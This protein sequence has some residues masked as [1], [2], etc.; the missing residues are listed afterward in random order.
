MPKEHTKEEFW[1]LYEKLPEDLKEMIF[2]EGTAD[3]IFNSCVRNGVDDE[4]ISEIAR[5]AGRVLLGILP[6]TEF[7]ETLERELKLEPE[8]AKRISRDIFRFVF[9]PV[10]SS[11]EILYRIEIAPPAKPTGITPPPEG[12]PPIPSKEDVY[13]EPVE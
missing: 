7:Q 13:R 2:S 6:P 9:Y 1:K 12:K 8:M 4:R 3:S 5:Y 10:K 11:L